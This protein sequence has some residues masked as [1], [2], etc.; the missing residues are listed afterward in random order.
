MAETRKESQKTGLAEKNQTS[1]TRENQ[2]RIN[3][4]KSQVSSLGNQTIATYTDDKLVSFSVSKN[5]KT[6]STNTSV[7]HLQSCFKEN[8]ANKLI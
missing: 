2:T 1:I 4:E 3:A 5:S 6:T 7:C 8:M